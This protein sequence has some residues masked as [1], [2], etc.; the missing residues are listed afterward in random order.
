[1]I[2]AFVGGVMVALGAWCFWLG[3]RGVAGTIDFAF[4]HHTRER[5]SPSAWQTAHQQSGRAIQRSGS[6]FVAA[7]IV[8]GVLFSAGGDDAGG[9]VLGG[10]S[11]VAVVV[12]LVGVFKG[13][14]TLASDESSRRAQRPG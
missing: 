12:M 4:G 5:S 13:L 14:S 3:G 8:A 10:L 2:G 6:V 9:L 7:G 1:M 11:L